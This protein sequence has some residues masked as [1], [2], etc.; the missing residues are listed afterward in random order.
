MTFPGSNSLA[1][2]VLLSAPYVARPRHRAPILGAGRPG[3]RG[4]DEVRV[5]DDLD[6]FE[7]QLFA[8]T[9]RLSSTA[10]DVDPRDLCAHLVFPSG[11]DIGGKFCR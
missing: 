6:K 1:A 10:R 8:S 3:W 9:I 4:G 7:L 2:R 11:E 5:M